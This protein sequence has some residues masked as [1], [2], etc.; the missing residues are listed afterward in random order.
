[1][2]SVS[3]V[4]PVKDGGPL[5]GRVLGAVR[6]QG[7]VELIVVDSG[8]RDGSRELARDAG[9]ELIDVPP[10]E[11]GHGRT[12]NLGAQRSHGELI[13]FLTQDAV[14]APGWLDAL[15]AGFGLAE[16]VGAVY[17]PH[18]PHPDT[19]PMIARELTEFFATFGGGPRI[20]GEG[21]PSFLSNV[22][23]AYRRACWDEIRF[24]DVR[25][26]EDQAFGRALAAHPPAEDESDDE[27]DRPDEER[28]RD[29]PP[30]GKARVKP[31]E[32]VA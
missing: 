5:L 1:M 22:N 3:V 15:V 8:S 27:G 10:E 31:V 12:R 14:P 2:P 24:D 32:R 25:Y 21:D 19:S 6:E 20:Y 4:I 16:R 23:A 9:A 30:V 17:G 29:R 13:A 28:K 18:L 11:F 26:S 7:E